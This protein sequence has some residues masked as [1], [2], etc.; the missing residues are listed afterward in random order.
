M[1]DI[2]EITTTRR[3]INQLPIIWIRRKHRSFDY[4]FKTWKRRQ[5]NA[6]QRVELA[7]ELEK[8]E[9]EEAKNKISEEFKKFTF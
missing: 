9:S 8:V 2:V 5:L 4:K 1:P 6:F 3:I 7:Y